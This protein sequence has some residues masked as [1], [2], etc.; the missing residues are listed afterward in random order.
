MLI[1]HGQHHEKLCFPNFE[2]TNFG[3]NF[4]ILACL[5]KTVV[6]F[7]CLVLGDCL[8]LVYLPDDVLTFLHCFADSAEAD[9][10]LPLSFEEVPYQVAFFGDGAWG[11]AFVAG[12]N[13]AFDEGVL[14]WLHLPVSVGCGFF[15]LDGSIAA[16]VVTCDSPAYD[17]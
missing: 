4:G 7:W 3:T 1:N 2:V 13:F 9:Y 15:F 16:V 12:W 14:S 8:F 5:P 10:S 6:W 11:E 17:R